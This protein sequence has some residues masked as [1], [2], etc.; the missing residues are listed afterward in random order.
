MLDVI[1]VWSWEDVSIAST[2]PTAISDLSQQVFYIKSKCLTLVTES[3]GIKSMLTWDKYSA[4]L[5]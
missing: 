4:Y 5:R 1:A 2:Y 3:Y